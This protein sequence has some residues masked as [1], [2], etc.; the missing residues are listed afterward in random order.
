MKYIAELTESGLY[1]LV[2]VKEEIFS[3]Y[4]ILDGEKVADRLIVDENGEQ[5]IFSPRVMIYKE[6]DDLDECNNFVAYM[7]RY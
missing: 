4:Y 6:F 1:N 7:N 2:V 3:T 5:R